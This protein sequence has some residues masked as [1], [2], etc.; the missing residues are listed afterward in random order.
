MRK[1][2]L[3]M[4]LPLLLAVAARAQVT[5]E[6]LL[7]DEQFLRS[8]SLPVRL[9]ISNLSGQTLRLGQQP[10]WL[11]FTIEAQ[12]G[13][14]LAKTGEVPL[15]KAFAVESS[16]TASLR[17]DL[18]PHFDLSEPGHYSIRARVKVPQL[19]Q[20][21][22]TATKT[23]DIVNGTK[24]WEKEVGVPGTDPLVV[25]KFTLQQAT[26]LKQLRLYVRITDANES[27][28]IRVFPLGTL[29]SFSAPEPAIDQSSQLHVLFQNGARSFLYSVIAPDGE[30]L[31]RQTFDQTT[32]R[33]RLRAE[34]DGR[35]T[36][37]GGARRIL[38]SDLPPPHVAKT[39][40]TVD[41]K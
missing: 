39:N 27:K 19:D 5:V 32:T 7:D 24:L 23:F 15:P 35:V 26:F 21:L 38:L 22:T 41:S 36:V 20:D 8:E 11:S 14:P 10:D 33:P 6:L 12:E 28:V 4:L 18:M 3:A 29:L 16:K 30:Q 9:K 34:Q 40:D 37:H 31:V 17:T 1:S 2:L 25:R 13:K